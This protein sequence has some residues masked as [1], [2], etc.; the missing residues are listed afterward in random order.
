M[1]DGYTFYLRTMAWL[2]E[3]EPENEE[4]KEQKEN[5]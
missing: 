5:E 2:N 4:E 1:M 3:T